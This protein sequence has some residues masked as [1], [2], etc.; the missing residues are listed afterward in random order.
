MYSF[1]AM[2]SCNWPC[3]VKW[4]PFLLHP[5]FFLRTSVASSYGDS[6][7]REVSY[8]TILCF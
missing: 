1:N 3:K 4:L 2:G 8:E 5:I 6:P 7:C